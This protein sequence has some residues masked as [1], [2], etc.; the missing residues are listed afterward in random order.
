LIL[1]TY[2]DTYI[3]NFLNLLSR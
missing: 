2:C 3:D 1:C